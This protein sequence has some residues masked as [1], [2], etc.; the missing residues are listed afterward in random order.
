MERKKASDYPQELL[1]LFHEY[2]HGEISRRACRRSSDEIVCKLFFTRWWISRI[3]ASFESNSRSRLRS[4]V[5]SRI[6]STPPVTTPFSTIGMHRDNNV[7]S[8][9]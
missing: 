6:K 3:V 2:Q 9:F 5:T 7:T 1:D 8:A 4:S